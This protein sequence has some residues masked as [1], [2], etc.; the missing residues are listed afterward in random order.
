MVAIDKAVLPDAAY[1]RE[2]KRPWKLFTFAVAMALLHYRALVYEI[3]DSR[4]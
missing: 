1:W 4:Q 3:F 2:L